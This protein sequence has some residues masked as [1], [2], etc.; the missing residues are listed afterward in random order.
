ML[1]ILQG[2]MLSLLKRRIA[3]LAAGQAQ[4]HDDIDDLI[5][6]PEYEDDS[7]LVSVFQLFIFAYSNAQAQSITTDAPRTNTL[8]SYPEF[9]RGLGIVPSLS[10]YSKFTTETVLFG[11]IPRLFR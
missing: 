11:L 7:V 5:Y 6:A 8:T 4:N 10:K 1:E 9:I 2:L 3:E